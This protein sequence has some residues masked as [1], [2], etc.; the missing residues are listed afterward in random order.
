MKY[1]LALL[2]IPSLL[3]ASTRYTVS[4]TSMTSLGDVSTTTNYSS[5]APSVSA[6]GCEAEGQGFN[7]VWTVPTLTGYPSGKKIDA[8]SSYVPLNIS[9]GIDLLVTSYNLIHI[10]TIAQATWTIYSTG[11][12]WSTGGALGSGTDYTTG[13]NVNGDLA[14]TNY[15][16]AIDTTGVHN[17]VAGSSAAYLI[18]PRNANQCLDLCKSAGVPTEGCV[19]WTLVIWYSDATVTSVKGWGRFN[20]DQ[21]GKFQ[22]TRQCERW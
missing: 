14:T 5:S 19:A 7:V 20:K 3:F 13:S 16:I 4:I 1:L 21:R 10:P 2:L 17:K 12:N 9:Y 22:R 18:T 11:N 8:C 6:S 15:A